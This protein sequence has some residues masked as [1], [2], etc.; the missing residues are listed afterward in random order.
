[1]NKLRSTDFRAILDC[2]HALYA[3]DD[4]ATFPQRLIDVLPAVL[5]AEFTSYTEVDP[6]GSRL[7]RAVINPPEINTPQL[8]RAMAPYV[9]EHP[10]IM[11]YQESGDG[12]AYQIS[13][14]LSQAEFH[15]LGLYQHFYRTIGVE[16]QLSIALPTSPAS[17]A[18]GGGAA[19]TSVIGVSLSRSAW[20]FPERDRQILNALRPHLLQ[21]HRNAAVKT[22]LAVALRA[23]QDALDR[24]PHGV[25]T[26]DPARRHLTLLS[27]P[28]ERLLKTY[29]AAPAR[30]EPLPE[31]LLSYVRV[32]YQTTPTAPYSV[33][34]DGH[35]LFV[36][37]LSPNPDGSLT[38]L[39]AEHVTGPTKPATARARQ[40]GL[41]PREAE[42]LDWLAEGK[43]N[44]EIAT[45]LSISPRT[46]QKHLE[47]AFQKLSV[48]TRSAAILRLLEPGVP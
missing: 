16:D 31:P 29:F 14:F 44:P 46:V 11:H 35:Q 6:A 2:A 26:L 43:T 41:T 18:R 47:H 10:V 36:Q 40:Y 24:L 1:M 15:R 20:R 39:L 3:H 33:R 17:G 30:G 23:S 28:A 8:A 4:F 32:P 13:D 19:A 38:L 22:Q 9:R 42:V 45:I 25:M 37:P 27:K 34:R 7:P 48:E 12:T 21:A 5:P